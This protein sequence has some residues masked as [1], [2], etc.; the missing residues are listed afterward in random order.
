MY[1]HVHDLLYILLMS[2]YLYDFIHNNNFKIQ[3]Q[4]TK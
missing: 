2:F 1:T 3:D 4:F